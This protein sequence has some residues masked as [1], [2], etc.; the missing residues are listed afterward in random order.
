LKILIVY[1]SQTKNTEKIANAIYDG[2]VSKGHEVDLKK[3]NEIAIDTL[4]NYN[5][6]FIGSACHDADVAK[7]IQQLINAIPKSPPYKIAGF[8]T[9]ATYTP[10]GTQRKKELY[11]KWAA[12][13]HETFEKTKEEKNVELLGYFSCMGVPTPAIAN[14]IQKAIIQSEEEWKEYITEVRKHPNKED[15]QNA[16]NFAEKIIEEY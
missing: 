2:V 15:L 6:I 13:C 5:L 3:I 11:Q 8:T 12:K 14:F 7:P 4:N 10:E 16:R 1:F 9:H